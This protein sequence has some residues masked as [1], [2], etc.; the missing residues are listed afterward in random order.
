MKLIL[1]ELNEINFD[2]VKQYIESGEKLENLKKLFSGKFI[3]TSAEKEYCNL[4][5]WI[6]WVSVH[7]GKT[8]EEHNIFRLGDIINSSDKQI[9]EKVEDAGFKVGAISPMNTK[10]NLKDPSYF[11]PDPWTKTKCDKS[12]LSRMLTYAISQAVNDNAQSKVTL[13][14]LI[15]L[16]ISLILSIKF[17]HLLELIIFAFTSIHKSWR[18]A[19]FLDLALFRIHQYQLEKKIPNFST[20]FLNAGAHIQHHYFHNAK[21]VKS[22]IRNPKWYIQEKKDPILDM[23]KIYDFIVGELFK[24]E[25]YEKI[26]ATGLSQRP[27]NKVEFY[28]R[29]KNHSAFLEKIGLNFK[30]VHPRMTRDFL[31]SFENEKESVKAEEV[32]SNIRVNDKEKLF[33]KLDNRGK[34]LFVTLTYENEIHKSCFIKLKEKKIN[35]FNETVF[36]AIKNGMHHEK[37]FAFFTNK[38]SKFAPDNNSHVKNIHSTILSLFGINN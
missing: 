34:D 30:D 13:K 20:L 18:K 10:N 24:I 28:Y 14:T 7:T 26:I 6:Q 33:S 27:F 19:L 2:F 23:L 1:L 8:F 16:S 3:L 37:G 9:F 5:P 29:L 35:I 31:I 21:I 32:L 17:T 38:V 36:V 25:G 4:E 22:S 12:I 11:V 15:F